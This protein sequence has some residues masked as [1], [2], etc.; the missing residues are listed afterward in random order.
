MQVTECPNYS[1]SREAAQLLASRI[2]DH[3]RQ[4]GHAEIETWVEQAATDKSGKPIF[5]VCSNLV[6]GLPP[7]TR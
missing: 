4:L 3:W 2:K 6:R 1:Y 7:R 5:A